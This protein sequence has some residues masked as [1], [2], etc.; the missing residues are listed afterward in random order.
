MRAEGGSPRLLCETDAA[1]LVACVY[2]AHTSDAYGARA[3]RATPSSFLTRKPSSD[4]LTRLYRPSIT[5]EL[6]PLAV[7]SLSS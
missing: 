3:V 5:G 1:A 7:L 2:A 4:R 6:R